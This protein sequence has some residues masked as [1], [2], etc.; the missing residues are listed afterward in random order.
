[1]ELGLNQAIR[2]LCEFLLLR[3]V[4]VVLGQVTKPLPSRAVAAAVVAAQLIFLLQQRLHHMLIQSAL[5][6]R[7]QAHPLKV[8]LAA[9]QLLLV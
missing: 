9:K 8:A 6:A 7:L 3:Q 2:F 1:V 4:A 5:A